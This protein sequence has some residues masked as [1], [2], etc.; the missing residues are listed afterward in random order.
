MKW[1]AEVSVRDFKHFNFFHPKVVHTL[2]ECFAIPTDAIHITVT[3]IPT[4]VRVSNTNVSSTPENELIGRGAIN[5]GLNGRHQ[6]FHHFYP[7]K[8]H[9]RE[10]KSPIRFIILSTIRAVS[11]QRSETIKGGITDV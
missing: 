6:K 8:I 2:N 1:F 9:Q 11:H 4:T 10:N 3:K 5:C 7:R